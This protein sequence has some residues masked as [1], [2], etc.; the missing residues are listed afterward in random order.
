MLD[1]LEA[2]LVDMLQILR[3]MVA[4]SRYQYQTRSIWGAAT[5]APF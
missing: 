1:L 4:W 2:A 5:Q 3:S